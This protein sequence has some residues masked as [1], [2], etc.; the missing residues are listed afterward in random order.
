MIRT[1]HFAISFAVHVVVLLLAVVRWNSSTVET[2][3]Q[4]K[5]APAQPAALQI[6]LATNQ[7]VKPDVASKLP[8][9]SVDLAPQKARAKVQAVEHKA[10]AGG[11]QRARNA[12][13][14]AADIS[15]ADSSTTRQHSASDLTEQPAKMDRLSPSASN[16]DLPRPLPGLKPTSTTDSSTSRAIASRQLGNSFLD[17]DRGEATPAF[18]ISNLDATQLDELMRDR[19]LLPFAIVAERQFCF[20]GPLDD[21]SAV[22]I[23]P[24]ISG[25]S[26]RGLQAS[27]TT[28][29]A[30]WNLLVKQYSF[31]QL[32]RAEAVFTLLIEASLDL[33]ILEAQRQAAIREGRLLSEVTCTFGRLVRQRDQWAFVVERVE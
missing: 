15:A 23:S 25:Y 17:S 6:N 11:I 14:N 20:E 7:D 22:R 12:N 1:R 18:V 5:N 28:T 27:P 33:E 29:A 19:K 31:R 30:C 26:S 4:S 10:I 9:P 8:S 2:N 13:S 16:G 3:E 24:D 32:Q 21:P